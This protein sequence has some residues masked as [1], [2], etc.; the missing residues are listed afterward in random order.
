MY[1]PSGDQRGI[2][3]RLERTDSFGDA[4][5]RYARQQLADGKTGDLHDIVAALRN[6]PS[7]NTLEHLSDPENS[8]DLGYALGA[9]SAGL[10]QLKK[11]KKDQAELLGGLIESVVGNLPFGG[12]AVSFASQKALDA[13]MGDVSEGR[14]D[15]PQALYDLVVKDLP[16]KIQN[17]IDTARGRVLLEQHVN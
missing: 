3:D 17:D 1:L 14:K 11:S 13:T 2:V 9:V 15:A 4:L 10:D 8:Q 6:G 5:T 16:A 7:G 12:D